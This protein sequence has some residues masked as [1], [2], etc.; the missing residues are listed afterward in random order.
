MTGQKPLEKPPQTS[1]NISMAAQDRYLVQFFENME[2]SIAAQEKTK[3][4]LRGFAS[5]FDITGG[6]IVADDKSGLSGFQKDYLAMQGDWANI[7]KDCRKAIE[8][9]VYAE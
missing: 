9:V 1:D 7:G 4:F 3:H 6:A 5:V 8:K 2:T